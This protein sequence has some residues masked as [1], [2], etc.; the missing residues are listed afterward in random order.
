MRVCIYIYIY[1]YNRYNPIRNHPQLGYIVWSFLLWLSFV[2]SSLFPSI[3]CQVSTCCASSQ[4]PGTFALQSGQLPAQKRVRHFLIHLCNILQPNSS[5]LGCQGFRSF[6]PVWALQTM[7]HSWTYRLKH[8]IGT[9][10]HCAWKLNMKIPK[11]EE[12]QMLDLYHGKM[13][14]LLMQF[15]L[16]QKEALQCP[17]WVKLAPGVQIMECLRRTDRIS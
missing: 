7:H 9:A 5:V 8:Y 13:S 6:I 11:V 2:V 4:W 17:S 12:L 1:T 14:V 10:M 3:H 16:I 15:V